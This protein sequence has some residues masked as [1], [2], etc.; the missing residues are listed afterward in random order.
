MFQNAED[1]QALLR[2][3]NPKVTT[4]RAS[5]GEVTREQEIDA[6]L[7]ETAFATADLLRARMLGRHG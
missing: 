5:K 6:I 1:L 7:S 4:I 3:L 2:C